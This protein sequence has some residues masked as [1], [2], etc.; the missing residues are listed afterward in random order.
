MRWWFVGS[1]S[2]QSAATLETLLRQGVV[3]DGVFIDGPDYSGSI[4]QG[5]IPPLIRPDV[6][7]GALEL[8]ATQGI[9]ATSGSPTQLQQ[10]VQG[11]RP[12][13]VL[14]SCYPHRISRLLL[15]AVPQGWLNI[16]P[17][18]LPAYRGI[19]P[20]FWQL[21]DGHDS[22]GVT[23]HR[24]NE[25]F[26]QG[27]IIDQCRFSLADFPDY[28]MINRRVGQYGAQLF[29]AYLENSRQEAVEGV[30]Q[31]ALVGSRQGPPQE[32]DFAVDPD[33]SAQRLIRFVRGVRGLA[34]PFLVDRAAGKLLI[35]DA[36]FANEARLA[37]P[38]P[39]KR[40]IHCYDGN[41]LLQILGEESE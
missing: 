21:R 31:D 17:S 22:I 32:R 40:L 24:M 14:V 41:V 39:G 13:R 26:D 28:G 33:W 20:V 2:A 6:S 4:A 1:R 15:T 7:P 37:A 29:L 34:T 11:N 16:H 18:L 8:A 12:E 19:N 38:L 3:P 25:I 35:E 23:L 10:L 27:P 36:A 5:V 9:A 30:A